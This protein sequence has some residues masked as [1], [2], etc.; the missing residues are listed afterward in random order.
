MKNKPTTGSRSLS[1]GTSNHVISS[2][3]GVPG[4]QGVS[5]SW[6]ITLGSVLEGPDHMR[7]S[8]LE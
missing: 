6:T 7:S 5:R 1:L 4:E 2:A 3:P 8:I